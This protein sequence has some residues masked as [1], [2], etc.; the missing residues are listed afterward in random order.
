MDDIGAGDEEHRE[1]SESDDDRR[2]QV[3]LPEDQRD[4]GPGD[5]Q[6]RDNTPPQKL[7]T[8]APR[9]ANQWAR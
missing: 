1:R 9:F 2:A 6:E 8:L 7:P 4:H 5:D 3:G